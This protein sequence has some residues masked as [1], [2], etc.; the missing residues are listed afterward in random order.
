MKRYIGETYRSVGERVSEHLKDIE[1]KRY[2]KSEVAYHFNQ[3]G[4]TDIQNIKVYILDFVYEH[5]ESKPA[6]K[7]RKNIEWNWIQR[8]RTTIPLGMN[9]MESRYG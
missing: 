1:H 2:G 3:A 5:P 7:L 8:L 6:N 9:I 4:C